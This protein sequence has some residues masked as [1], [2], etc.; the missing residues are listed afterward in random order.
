MGTISEHSVVVANPNRV[1]CDLSGELAILNV[2]NGVYYGLDSIGARVWEWIQTPKKVGEILDALL[3]DYAVEPD[4]CKHDLW[5]LLEKLST[6][7]L[8]QIKN[9]NFEE[10]L[11]RT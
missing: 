6:N 3:E 4:R 10:G 7:G 5:L 1:S 9:E 8:V 11:K 2:D